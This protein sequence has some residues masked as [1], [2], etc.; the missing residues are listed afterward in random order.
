MK[1]V[2]YARTKPIFQYTHFLY[3]SLTRKMK[4]VSWGLMQPKLESQ[5]T[6]TE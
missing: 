4:F 6:A 5:T 1:T 2:E 3:S